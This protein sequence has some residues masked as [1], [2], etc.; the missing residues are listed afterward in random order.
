MSLASARLLLRASF[1]SLNP[2]FPRIGLAEEGS[3]I[4]HSVYICSLWFALAKCGVCHWVF[5][6]LFIVHP[7]AILTLSSDP[8]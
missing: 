4:I 6:F 1:D 8:S 3:F 2:C 7:V 5:Q